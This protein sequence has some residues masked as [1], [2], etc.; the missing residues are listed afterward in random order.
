M[1]L[2]S[3]T[4]IFFVCILFIRQVNQKVKEV[5]DNKK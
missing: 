4:V 5:Y 1:N 3:Y 2:G